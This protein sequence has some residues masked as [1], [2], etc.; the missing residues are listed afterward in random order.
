MGT[1]AL[2]LAGPAFGA[3]TSHSENLDTLTFPQAVDFSP[4]DLSPA[5]WIWYPGDRSNLPNTVILFRRTVNLKAAPRSARGWINGESRYKLEVNAKRIQWGPAPNDPRWPEIDPM[6]LS[7]ELVAGENT[8]G[9]TVLFY[10]HGDGTWPMGLPGFI[11]RLEIEYGD[12][13]REV[14]V[15]DGD[16]HCHL[17]RAWRPGQHARSFLHAFQEEYD[18]RLHPVGWL[19]VGYR[20]DRDWVKASMLDC[21]SDKPAICVV[22]KPWDM[23]YGRSVLREKMGIMHLRRRNIS[24]M[25]ETW[26]PVA[27]LSEQH[28]IEWLRPPE[29]YFA[30]RPTDAYRASPSV[31]ATREGE[32]GWSFELDPERGTT[33]TFEMHEQMVGWPGFTVEAPVGTIIELMVH[34]AHEIG[35]PALLNTG[36]HAWTRFIC[37]EGENRFG[38]FDFQTQRWIQLHFH[39]GRGRVV[40][41]QVGVLRRVHPWPVEPKVTTSEAPLQKLFDATVNTLRNCAQETLVDTMGRER[42]QYSGDI[43]HQQH[44]LLLLCGETRQVARFLVTYS[45]GIT[46]DGYFLDCWPAVDRLQRLAQRQLDLTQWGPLIDHGVQFV[47]DGWHY[48]QYTGDPEPFKEVFPRYLRF[49]GYLEGLIGDDGMLRVE[50]LGTPWIWIN[51]GGFPKQRHKKCNFNLFVAEMFGRKLAEL[52]R[53]FGEEQ[54]AD[55][56]TALGQR[57]LKAVQRAFWSPVY[58]CFVDNLPWLAEERKPIYHDMTLGRSI[59]FGQCPD[60]NITRSLDLLTEMPKEVGRAYAPLICWRLWALS[61]GRRPEA[62]LRELR[63]VW[64]TL[65]SVLLNNTISETLETKP[66]THLQWSHAAIVPIYVAAMSLAGI[67]PLEPGFDRFETRPQLADLR[68]LKLEVTTPHGV[69]GFDAKGPRGSRQLTLTLPPKAKGELAVDPREELPLQPA[70]AAGRFYLPPGRELKLILKHT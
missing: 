38:T 66:D 25:H 62:V 41:S 59:L 65:P 22:T 33:L 31:V 9:V 50:D 60:G 49:A 52:C 29:E 14:I 30:V 35:G 4:L 37:R 18:A 53:L 42:Q 70:G 36:F 63:E 39:S 32:D 13:S 10:G 55:H 23:L 2:L 20:M 12:G 44:A 8:I 3:S 6:D 15:S 58:G 48:Y 47:F 21:A 67:K 56:Y 28:R 34:D 24:M 26:L 43:A 16:W 64:A 45:Q 19:A 51:F 68:D 54:K 11:F 40:V 46:A 17:S 61:E 7:R 5:K 1:G 57:I 27:K 69:I